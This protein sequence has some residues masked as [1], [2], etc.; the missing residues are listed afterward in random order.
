MTTIPQKEK[1][2][3]LV[4]TAAKDSITEMPPVEMAELMELAPKFF[5]GGGRFTT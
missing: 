1:I 2:D 3:V 4:V 5:K